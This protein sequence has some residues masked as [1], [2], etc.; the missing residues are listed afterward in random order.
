[1][2]GIVGLI[3]KLPREQALRQVE[4]MVQSLLHEAFYTSGIYSNECM[5]LYIG[6]VARKGS[7][8][9]QMPL[10]DKNNRATLIFSGEE[11]GQR[12]LAIGSSDLVHRYEN[13]PHFLKNLNG[14]FQG[15]L[16]DEPTSTV[17]LFNDR[18]GLSRLYFHESKDAFYFSAE[19]KALLA[20][21]PELRATD[22]QGLGELM[23]CGCVLENRTIFQG[24]RVLPAGSAWRFKGGEL[25]KREMYF[26]AEEWEGQQHL[27]AEQYYDRFQD[28]FSRIIPS[29]LGGTEK[30]GVSLTGGLDS[31]MIMAWQ[32]N[33]PGSLNC[34]TFSGMIRE[35][36]DAIV[37][38]QV[39]RECQQPH[40]LITV[41]EEFL[42][43]FPYY[44]ER[45]VYLTDGCVDVS[46][47]ADLY[48]NERVRQ[49]APIRVTGNYGGELLR[50]VRAFK[51]EK[52]A[53]GPF[54]REFLPYI[55]KAAGAYSRSVQCDGVS[56][57]AFRQTPWHHY[58]LQ[59]LEETQVAMRT[60][61]LD[62]DLVKTVFQAPRSLLASSE[63]S[64]RL[65]ADGNN[66][67]TRIKTDRG[68]FKR[69]GLRSTISHGI[70][71]MRVKA[72][73]LYD[74]GMWD[75]VTRAERWVAPFHPERIFLGRQK[76]NHFR[77]WYKG[78]LRDYVREVLLD[79]RTLSRPYFEK[80]NL[81]IM[82]ESHLK[83][84]GN[85]TRAIHK[86]L[87][88]ELIHRRFVDA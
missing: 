19:A 50:G 21:R 61:F 1:M 4:C 5:G 37:A 52:K 54:N 22:L 49:I 35:C 80:Q 33:P 66:A 87:T 32:R 28:V 9:E 45:A 39:A 43:R 88:L 3:T 57:A 15:A 59:A 70:E 20:V 46:R 2:P 56:F 51:P 40:E 29:Y 26:Q 7:T 42:S 31:R 41:G 73:Y 17:T 18:Y 11:F 10:R 79:P 84:V 14:R 77:I 81:T 63:L 58:G 55:Q 71:E 38:R 60:P 78:A 48:A 86:A 6:W 64:C 34:Y 24:I 36:Q 16:L 62:N 8:F 83:G 44:A 23:A 12:S 85:H 82:V 69:N 72:E 27:S 75:W 74:Y 67:L 53:D 30:I 76:F 65:I 13:D 25:I 68:T 47:G